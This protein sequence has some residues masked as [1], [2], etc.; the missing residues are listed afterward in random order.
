[1]KIIELFAGSRSFSRVA[2]EMGHE[3][4]TTDIHPFPGIDLQANIHDLTDGSFP[5]QPDVV[6]ASPPCTTFSVA[7]IGSHWG[8]DGKPKTKEGREGMR[9][10][11]RTISLIRELR[12]KY[13]FIENPRGMMRARV[14]FEH[15]FLPHYDVVRRE[16]TY[17]QYGDKRMKPTDIWTNLQ[18]WN[19][20]PMCRPKDRC[21]ESAPRGSRTGTQGLATPYERSRVP[22]DLC[23][24]ILEVLDS[25]EDSL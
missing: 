12:P 20:R 1:M 6:W 11:M 5:Y 19:P 18:A 2:K 4:F 14:N 25:H 13:F 24:E 16:V 15:Q 7:S 21:H 3:V 23:R 17:C 22:P 9:I 8:K 10:V